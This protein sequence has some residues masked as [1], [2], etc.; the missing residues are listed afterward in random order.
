MPYISVLINRLI[1]ASLFS[2]A[3]VPQVLMADKPAQE[4]TPQGPLEVLSPVRDRIVLN[5]LWKALPAVAPSADAPVDADWGTIWVPG[6]WVGGF[7]SKGSGDEWATLGADLHKLWYQRE[8]DIPASWKG[9][10]ILVDFR[11]VSTDATVS[12]NGTPCGKVHWPYGL[13]D[14]TKAVTPGSKATLQVLVSATAD[15]AEHALPMGPD[16]KQQLHTANKLQ[17]QGLIGEVFLLSEPQGPVVTN[18]FVQPSVRQKQL[19][20]QVEVSGMTQDETANVTAAIQDDSGKTV[21]TFQN[22]MPLKAAA[23]QTTELTFPWP[24]PALWTPEHPNLYDL[25]LTVEGTAIHDVYPQQFGFREFWVDDKKFILNG[26]EIRLRP[27]V[28]SNDAPSTLD[29]INGYIDGLRKAGFNI[30]EQQPIDTDER[31]FPSQQREVW[32]EIAD[33]KGFLTIADAID[34]DSYLTQ[35]KKLTWWDPGVRDKYKARFEED[36]RRYRNHPCVVM[37][38]TTPNRYGQFQDQNPRTIGVR[39][40]QFPLK[41]FQ[42]QDIGMKA[43]LDAMSVIRTVDPTR[44]A[45]TMRVTCWVTFTRSTP[46]L[47]CSRSRN[48]RSG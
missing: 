4:P 26:Q 1:L 6:G 48:G 39:E 17:S 32:C 35:D 15:T 23:V 22:T 41:E 40:I 34:W 28:L 16:T 12:V 30:V 46:T 7:A 31:G 19:T 5:G 10:R 3:L 13:V 47:I 8:I 2:L 11:R 43:G 44:P 37:Y 21:K 33:K 20:L 24:D 25:V 42:L 9:R 36:S 29:G 14:I 45:Y 27:Q 18:V 38:T